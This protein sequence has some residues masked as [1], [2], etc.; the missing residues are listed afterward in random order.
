MMTV[1]SSLARRQEGF[2]AVET[3]LA[4]PIVLAM[5][6][7]TLSSGS[8]LLTKSQLNRAVSEAAQYASANPQRSD[9]QIREIVLDSYHGSDA[10]AATAIDV[11]RGGAPGDARYI[12]VEAKVRTR[13]PTVLFRAPGITLVSRKKAFIG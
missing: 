7:G 2:A 3:I 5:A 9:A 6:L 1:F 10:L 8:L 12:E 4:L 13:L 11:S